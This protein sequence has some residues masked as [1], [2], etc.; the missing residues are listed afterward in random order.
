MSWF[1]SSAPAGPASIQD[2]NF[3]PVT[4]LTSGHGP[5]T[6][7]DTA[8][9]LTTNKGFQTETQTWYS[10]LSD[11]TL[12]LTQV[13]WSCIGVWMVPAQTQFT[14][15][16]HNPKTGETIWRSLN[17]SNFALD[18]ADG[19]SCRANEFSIT[20]TGS[21]RE[22]E[23]EKY[24]IK[25][26]L[27]KEGGVVLDV[28]FERLPEAPGFKLGEGESGGYSRFGKSA[29]P[30]GGKDGF[31]IHRFHP[32]AKSSGT[33]LLK[34]RPVDAAGD[35]M[36]VHAIQGMM[37]NKVASRWNFAFFTSGGG[38]PSSEYTNVRAIQMEFETTDEYGVYGPKSGR[39]KCNLG[40][41][42]LSGGSDSEKG[43]IITTTGQTHLPSTA[44]ATTAYPLLPA[45]SE[46]QAHPDVS[47]ATHI[48]AQKEE[49][50][51]YD[52]PARVK[53]VWDGERRD[54]Q[55]RVKGE[56]EVETGRE[57]G[58]KGLIEKV[59]VL[60]EIPYLVKKAL[61]AVVGVKPYIFQYHNSTTLHLQLTDKDGKSRDV[62]V[63]G[64]LFNEASFIS[65]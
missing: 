17:A 57:K 27:D 7:T 16:L 63:E 36:F 1:S 5:L 42:Y 24:H 62:N 37:P 56:I 3:W 26:T 32:L 39:V 9:E 22:G 46:K 58:E 34:G 2:C 55:G 45:L 13:I 28:T 59:D 61:S 47:S 19:R 43:T 11:G 25:A 30:G 65:P 64:W 33:I 51:G 52:A 60:A 12:L 29:E 23:P 41:I 40:A 54:A 50:T 35:A 20:H 38:K 21:A 31:V 4:S 6:E 14:F 44:A 15:K 10:V 53:F 8:W 49:S 18:K 48:G